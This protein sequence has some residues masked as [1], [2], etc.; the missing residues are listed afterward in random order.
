[1]NLPTRAKQ[2][3]KQIAVIDICCSVFFNPIFL[4]FQYSLL[5]NTTGIVLRERLRDMQ[6]VTNILQGFFCL[7]FLDERFRFRLI[8]YPKIVECF[9]KMLTVRLTECFLSTPCF[10]AIREALG[11]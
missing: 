11:R 10:M 9:L 7:H 6:S 1:M 2:L 8:P 4:A 5:L 3:A